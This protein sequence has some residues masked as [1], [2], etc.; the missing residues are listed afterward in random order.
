MRP[1]DSTAF[2]QAGRPFA[3][4]TIVR[5]YS[6]SKPL[7]SAAAMVLYERG[8]F[9]FADQRVYVSGGG[10]DGAEMVCRVLSDKYQNRA[11]VTR[12]HVIGDRAS[13]ARG[14]L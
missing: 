11:I 5:L 7:V 2:V 8:D 6:M 10:E 13:S 3:G 14:D 4:D 1:N 12:A 9:Q